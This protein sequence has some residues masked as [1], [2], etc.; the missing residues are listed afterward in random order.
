MQKPK[1]VLAFV[2]GLGILFLGGEISASSLNADLTATDALEITGFRNIASEPKVDDEISI[3]GQN[4]GNKSADLKV[5]LEET[6]YPVVVSYG[7][8]LKFKLTAAMQS[9]NLFVKKTVT[10][11]ETSETLESNLLYL[12]LK[13][14]K[15]KKTEA[16][17]GLLPHNDLK[18]YGENLANAAFF[19]GTESLEVQSAEATSATI[20]LPEKFLDCSIIAKKS[21]F[22]VSTGNELTVQAPINLSGISFVNDIFKVYGKGFTNYQNDLAQL[23]LV[24]SDGSSLTNPTFVADGEINFAKGSTLLP[25]FGRAALKV[26]T[27]S[28]PQFDYNIGGDFPAVTGI[29]NLQARLDG[30]VNYRLDW[31]GSFDRRSDMQFK[32][33]NG[34]VNL[35]GTQVEATS[36]PTATGTAWVEMDGW[37]SR[38]LNYELTETLVPKITDLQIDSTG[39]NMTISGKNFG[40]SESEFKFNSTLTNLSLINLGSTEVKFTLPADAATGEFSL[41]I[42]SKWG[43]SNTVNFTLPATNR[44]FYAKPVITE[45]EAVE[46]LARGKKIWI[47]GENLLN[48]STANF[49]GTVVAVKILSATK[50]EV[51]PPANIPLT[52]KL[53][54]SDKAG[55]ASAE[56]AYE[57]LATNQLQPIT[58]EFPVTAT[59]AIAQNDDWQNLFAFSVQNN[60]K[61]IELDLVEFN[62]GKQDGQLALID[63]QLVDTAGQK[64]AGADVELSQSGQQVRLRNVPVPVAAGKTVFT[65]QAKIFRQLETAKNYTFSV[66]NLFEKDSV[67]ITRKNWQKKVMLAAADADAKW[68]REI[69]GKE[70]QE[71][72]KRVRRPVRRPTSIPRGKK[73]F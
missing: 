61:P 52:G 51:V 20:E 58:F 39:K 57:L 22:E 24:F 5:N 16:A 35:V 66:G 15:I 32:V 28:S 68:C 27:I 1:K 56:I 38:V 13:T 41:G 63:F 4:F 70:W 65:L 55:N 46:G 40:E 72:R 42:S 3:S 67:S 26:D 23:S 11:G 60:Q 43:S 6:D 62:F 30:K 34:E 31:N 45:I 7:N 29:S 37:K 36:P 69:S 25:Y 64:I 59:G 49:G 12:D 10:V 18:F 48:A 47:L 17:T 50:V 19:C 14:P 21:G 54:V 2:L 73:T 8:E 33:N 9:G 53:T 44:R 71:C